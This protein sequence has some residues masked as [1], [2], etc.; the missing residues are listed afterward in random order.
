MKKFI[1]VLTCSIYATLLFAQKNKDVV[2]F[3]TI[4]PNDFATNVYSLD[5]QANAIVLYNYGQS[6]MEA[7]NEGSF[8]LVNTFH[9]K[10][11]ILNKKAFDLANFKIYLFN[12]EGAN[13]RVESFQ[14]AT[15]N[16]VNGE[17][18]ST[19]VEKS[20]IK[21]VK[22]NKDTTVQEFTF[23]DVQEGS[24]IECYY[25][26]IAPDFREMRDWFF[27]LS[28]PVLWSEF[29]FIYPNMFEFVRLK[30]G[31][32]KYLEDTVYTTTEHYD[33]MV[34]EGVDVGGFNGNLP[35][36]NNKFVMQNIPSMEEQN[37]VT[38]MSN[39]LASIRFYISG[40]RL[41]GVGYKST[42]P[43]WNALSKGLM[44]SEHFGADINK[45]PT[46]AKEE[47]NTITAGLT[48]ELDKAKKIYYYIQSN[49]K[50]TDPSE[51]KISTPIKKVFQNKKGNVIEVNALLATM[52]SAANLV[53]KP[54][55]L[56]TR[57][58]GKPSELYP[59]I[60]EFNYMVCY[61]E[62]NNQ[63]YFL[64]A[65]SNKLGFG[66][67]PLKCYNGSARLID[68][69][70]PAIINISADSLVEN[71]KTNV[72]I[73][74]K[75]D[76][77]GMTG[78]ITS[79][80]GYAKSTEI[81]EQLVTGNEANIFNIQKSKFEFKT[82]ITNTV[83]ENLTDLEAPLNLKYNFSI[84]T[85]PETIHFLPMLTE[86]IKENPFKGAKRN[87][88]IEMPYTISNTYLFNME[89]PKGYEVAEIPKSARILL[90]ETEGMFEYLIAKKSTGSIQLKCVVKI[91]VA[92]FKAAEDF[93]TL[94]GFYNFI[95]QKQAEPIVFKKIK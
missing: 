28:Y 95:I 20:T 81:R 55:L 83:L 33:I 25:K 26:I 56:S 75:E 18:K 67:L 14:A 73:I 76:G 78:S 13:E 58:N 51:I 42:L 47:V 31:F 3:G 68:T 90:N 92:N 63:K 65:T 38:S 77:Q 9:Q 27:Q 74:N 41:P 19:K 89:I 34:P 39:N 4:T 57:E 24:I 62:I 50:T 54:V 93:D 60:D 91:N 21:K 52:L 84:D 2:K 88:P 94:K 6:K 64:D 69:A 7:N 15:Y 29:Y 1:T 11:K 10:I 32:H 45:K 82:D 5:S 61:V 8:S 72:Y 12:N 17:V 79:T 30:K 87:Y 71:T 43:T 85:E 49:I 66:K 70:M 40:V 44:E 16:L 36:I 48:D 46:W 80:L 86:A 35:T 22:L 23:Q 53:V 37:F 59:I